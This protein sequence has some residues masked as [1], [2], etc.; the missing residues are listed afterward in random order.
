VAKN[1]RIWREA[2]SHEIGAFVACPPSRED[3][4]DSDY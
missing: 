4:M 3:D 2:K 1:G